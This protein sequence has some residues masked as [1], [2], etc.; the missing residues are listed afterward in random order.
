MLKPPKHLLSRWRGQESAQWDTHLRSACELRCRDL[1][2]KV[3]SQMLACKYTVSGQGGRWQSLFVLLP[4]GRSSSFRS[5]PVFV[6]RQVDRAPIVGCLALFP[7]GRER[8][9]FYALNFGPSGLESLPATHRPHQQCCYRVIV[10]IN[11]ISK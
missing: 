2:H 1:W 8:P 11:A 5:P 7:I 6:A 10:N 9:Q 3:G 4:F